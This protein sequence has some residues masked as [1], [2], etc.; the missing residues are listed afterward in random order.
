MPAPLETFLHQ[1]RSGHTSLTPELYQLYGGDDLLKAIQQYDPGAHWTDTMTGGGEGGEGTAS[2]RLDFDLTKMP[3]SKMPNGVERAFHE[4]APSNM[5]TAGLKNS[6]YHWGDD[7]YGDVTDAR[8]VKHK[9]EGIE[10]FA[11]LIAAAI[12]F[13]G[14]ALAGALAGAGI[15]GAGLTSAATG[16]GLTGLNSFNLPNWLTQTLGKAPTYGR[17]LSQGTFDPLSALFN[18]GGNAAGINPYLLKG[19]MT[20]ADLFRA[21]SK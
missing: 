16:S 5:T 11:P 15:G 12:S 21:R 3:T 7:L 4:L 9:S 17:Q 20:L 14:P 13:G 1:Y 2:K 10:K 18:I 6:E 19:G 8:N